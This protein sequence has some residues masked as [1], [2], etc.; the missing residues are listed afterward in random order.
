[1]WAEA[2]AQLLLELLDLPA[3]RRLNDMEL[4]RGSPEAALR[5]D[6]REISKVAKLHGCSS[7]DRS[8]DTFQ[9]SI[10]MQSVLGL[11]GRRW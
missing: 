1:V 8:F 11:Q 3:E 5:R 10:M 9:V 4:S 6:R 2:R 7:Q